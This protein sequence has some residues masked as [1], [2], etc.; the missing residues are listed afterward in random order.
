[1][2]EGVHSPHKRRRDM[3]WNSLRSKLSGQF[4]AKLQRSV[5]RAKCRLQRDVPDRAAYLF[6]GQHLYRRTVML[7]ANRLQHN[8][9]ACSRD[10]H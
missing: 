9:I 8:W 10:L 5:Y 1:M 4:A 6:W 3:Q 2:C 7:S